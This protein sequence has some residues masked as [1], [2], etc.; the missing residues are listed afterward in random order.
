MKDILQDRHACLAAGGS[1]LFPTSRGHV[2]GYSGFQPR[3][4]IKAV[5]PQQWA[6]LNERN[7]PDAADRPGAAAFPPPY[8]VAGVAGVAEA[9]GQTVD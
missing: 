7:A 6:S 9:W 5:G 1:A 2:S 3:C 8:G 4:P